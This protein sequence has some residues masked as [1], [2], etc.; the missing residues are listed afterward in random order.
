VEEYSVDFTTTFVVECFSKEEEEEEEETEAE[1]KEE[2]ESMS[3]S[4]S[5]SSRRPFGVDPPT[6]SIL[7]MVGIADETDSVGETN[8]NTPKK[9]TRNDAATPPRLLS[10]HIPLVDVVVIITTIRVLVLKTF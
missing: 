10:L 3:L 1:E 9:Q 8:S 4:P 2:I 5:S 6:D 7:S